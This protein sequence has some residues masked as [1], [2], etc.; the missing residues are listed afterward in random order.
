MQPEEEDVF[1]SFYTVNSFTEGQ[2]PKE[3]EELSEILRVPEET[4]PD[5]NNRLDNSAHLQ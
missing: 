3:E 2:D 1:Y 4:H 5:M